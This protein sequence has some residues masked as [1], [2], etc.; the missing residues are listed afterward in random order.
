MAGLFGKFFS[1]LSGAPEHSVQESN[2]SSKR[3]MSS[4]DDPVDLSFVKRFTDGGG[5]F[6]YC[7]G[8]HLYFI[9]PEEDAALQ[10]VVESWAAIQGMSEVRTVVVFGP[11]FNSKALAEA[12]LWCDAHHESLRLVV[13]SSTQAV[14]P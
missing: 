3:Y 11:H 14:G 13:R 6:V 8:N 4:N 12:A 1:I 2:D 10:D 5:Y 7:C 9:S